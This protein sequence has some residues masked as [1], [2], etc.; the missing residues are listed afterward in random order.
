M[1][2][3]ETRNAY[4]VRLSKNKSTL[5]MYPFAAH[6]AIPVLQN[7][8]R[9]NDQK[10]ICFC[11]AALPSQL[12]VSTITLPDRSTRKYIIRWHTLRRSH[13][14]I[15]TTTTTEKHSLYHVIGEF[16]K[17]TNDL[18]L[19]AVLAV[20]H[21]CLTLWYLQSI[22]LLNFVTTSFSQPTYSK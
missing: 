2:I 19:H 13:H 6:I 3:I 11:S 18:L 8:A 22:I 12:S 10:I 17:C 20:Y 15:M 14:H 7:C 4:A 5:G 21:P 16:R 9:Q 1:N